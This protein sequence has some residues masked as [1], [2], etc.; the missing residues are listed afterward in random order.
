MIKYYV[1]AGNVHQANDYRTKNFVLGGGWN[2]VY[3]RGE[4]DLIGLRDP[5]GIFI[6]TWYERTDIH[7]IIERLRICSTFDNAGIKEAYRILNE[8]ETRTLKQP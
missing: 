4:M 8:K 1:V 2:F 6:G 3:V 5:A 7:K